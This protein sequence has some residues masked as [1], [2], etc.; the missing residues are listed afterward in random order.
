MLS[1]AFALD[2]SSR[3]LIEV[4]WRDHVVKGVSLCAAPGED[5]VEGS[6]E[7]RVVQPGPP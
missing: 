4:G 7:S 2:S 1:A 3:H 5:L 6:V